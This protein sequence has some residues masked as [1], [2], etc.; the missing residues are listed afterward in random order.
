MTTSFN[1]RLI[2]LIVLS[3]PLLSWTLSWPTAR[4]HFLSAFFITWVTKKIVDQPKSNRDILKIGSLYLLSLLS[5][6]ISSLAIIPAL[7]FSKKNLSEEKF[8]RLS[9]VMISIFLAMVFINFYYYKYVYPTYSGTAKIMEMNL[10]LFVM[11]VFSFS[12]SL[13]Q[14]IF[15]ISF[16]QTYNPRTYLSFIGMPFFIVSFYL[17]YLKYNLKKSL[18]FALFI[19]YPLILIL[20]RPTNIFV[21]DT[22]I[23]I[24]LTNTFIVIGYV[25]K[26]KKISPLFLALPILLSLK[27]I[28]EIKHTSSPYSIFKTSF[29]REPN[30][31][32]AHSYANELLKKNMQKEFMQ[33]SGDALKNKC[34]ILGKSGTAVMN[35]NFAFR[36]VLDKSFNL[37]EKLRILKK[38]RYVT[39]QIEFLK[40]ILLHKA[41]MNESSQ[42]LLSKVESRIQP[43]MKQILRSVS[44]EICDH[45]KCPRP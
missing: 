36:I 25:F 4:K 14:I 30:C 32:N 10:H 7:L 15:P 40:A 13:T 43:E 18:F 8:Y 3:H 27:S 17:V 26:Y 29:D 35:Q 9:I 24:S 41:G 23:I 44:N 39:P 21:S 38:M 1:S 12:R 28:H 45:Q 42:S 5:Q 31:K 16:S 19:F 20:A 34:A 33:I 37:K 2:A 11:Q 6:P 22:Y